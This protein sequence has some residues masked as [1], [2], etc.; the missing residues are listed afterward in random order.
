MAAFSYAPN[1][2]ANAWAK[3]FRIAL[4]LGILQDFATGVPAVLWPNAALRILG[5]THSSDPVYVSLAAMILLML[6]VMYIPA[7]IDPY[8]YP[9]VAWF[10]VLARPPGI[11]FF[12]FLYPHQYPAFAIVDG[13]FTALQL[14]LLLLTFYAPAADSDYGSQYADAPAQDP[15]AQPPFG[16]LGTTFND[17]HDVVWSDPYEKLPHHMGLGPIKLVPFF[18]NSSRN[19]IDKRDLLPRFEKLIHANGICHT[20]TWEITAETPYTGYFKTGSRGLVLVRM[21]VAGLTV[22]PLLPRAF[23]IAGKIFPTM[24]PNE[25]AQPANFVTVSRLSGIR[26]KYIVDIE[27]T[28]HPAVGLDPAAFLTSRVIFRLLDTRPGLRLLYPISTL[29]VPRGGPIN[30][31][32]LMLFKIADGMPRIAAND[33]REELRVK[34]YPHGKII[35]SIFVR[36]FDEA[37]WSRIGQLTLTKDIVSESGDQRLHFWIPRDIPGWSSTSS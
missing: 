29:G 31:P 24:D 5:Q 4:W 27:V 12:G 30:T 21:S 25:H 13:V 16:Y 34:H 1:H 20:G 2:R 28:N 35:F 32:D 10:S 26:S 14:P 9:A 11:I 6:G 3:W 8:K 36:N 17:L 33:F 15:K 7:A 18:N 23:G 22:G 37:G 19:L